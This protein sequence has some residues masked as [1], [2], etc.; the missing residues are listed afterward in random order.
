MERNA[1]H[2]PLYGLFVGLLKYLKT[3]A[4]Y[5]VSS[6][7]DLIIDHTIFPSWGAKRGVSLLLTQ[8]CLLPYPWWSDGPGSRNTEEDNQILPSC[9]GGV[10]STSS[11]LGWSSYWWAV[12]PLLSHDFHF[13]IESFWTWVCRNRP[14]RKDQYLAIHGTNSISLPNWS[15]P[16][17]VFPSPLPSL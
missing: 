17:Q 13:P 5:W 2:P 14:S 12:P 9:H 6:V 8:V 10:I 11:H 16:R 15:H 7:T 3:Q 1:W 4:R